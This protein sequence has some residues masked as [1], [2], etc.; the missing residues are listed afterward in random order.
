MCDAD[1]CFT[2]FDFKSYGSNNDC[3]VLANSWLG[4]GLESNKSQLP[5]DESVDGCAFSPMPYYL[6]GDNIFPL[7]KWLIKPYP[8]KHLKEEQK[9]YN[10]RLSGFRRLI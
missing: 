1:Y 5:P 8:G 6:L 3:G 9:I 7:K 4:K 2:L 10:C